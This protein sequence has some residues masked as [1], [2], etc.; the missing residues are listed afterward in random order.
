[1]IDL[2]RLLEYD[3][4]VFGPFIGEIEWEFLYWCGFIRWLKINHPN[5]H[6]VVSTRDICYDLYSNCLDDEDIE[7]FSIVDDFIEYPPKGND[8]PEL[9]EHIYEELFYGLKNKYPEHFF[10]EPRDYKQITEISQKNCMNL[11]FRVSHTNTQIIDILLSSNLKKIPICI[12]TYKP[13]HPYKDWGGHQWRYLIEALDGC[14]EYLCFVIGSPNTY[15]KIENTRNTYYLELYKD[16]I[17]NSLIGLYIDAIRESK[18][19][20][21]V[22]NEYIEMAQLLETPC[23]T[24]GDNIKRVVNTDLKSIGIEDSSYSVDTR[25]ILSNIKSFLA[26]QN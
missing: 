16:M 12:N 1:M 25:I 22:K 24:W 19:F 17:G 15:Y 5:K 20:V 7:L 26:K 9:T 6:V 4:I 3:K 21:G 23:I 18:V 2:N 14:D 13:K 10:I 8:S 11:D